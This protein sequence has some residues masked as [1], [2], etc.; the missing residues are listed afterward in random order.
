MPRSFKKIVYGIF[1]LFLLFLVVSQF[2]R[3][4][5]KPEPTCFDGRKNQNEA[6]VDCGDVCSACEVLELAP[7]KNVGAV[8]IFGLNAGR[9]VFLA[10]IS[11]PN[12]SYEAEFFYRFKIYGRGSEL[13]ET[14]T[15]SSFIFASKKRFLYEAGAST[16]AAD[17]VRVEVEIFEPQW[18]MVESSAEAGLVVSPVISTDIEGTA[19]QV[20]GSVKNTSPIKVSNMEVI[21][22]IFDKFGLELFASKTVLK[23]LS[24][25]EE[26]TFI[27]NFPADQFLKDRI[28]PMLSRVFI[29]H[30]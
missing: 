23:N 13:I 8:K 3:A 25:F 2:Y 12:K 29:H 20:G 4:Y 10:E 27:V 7:L 24:G 1:Y 28:D 15:G 5:L 30:D 26:R 11:N 14:L 22:I 21:A 9:T 18:K 6:G 17:I 19:I 16:I